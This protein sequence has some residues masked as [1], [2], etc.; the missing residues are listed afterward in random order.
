MECGGLAAAFEAVPAALKLTQT[1]GLTPEKREQD[2]RTPKK[3]RRRLL[4]A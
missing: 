4:A 3:K 1:P 2:S